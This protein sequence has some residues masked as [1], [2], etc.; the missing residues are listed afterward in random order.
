MSYC[1]LITFTDGE[2]KRAKEF[3]NSWGGA[4]RIWTPLYDRYLKDPN[5]PYDSWLF[6]KTDRLW[7]L[8]KRESLQLFERSVHAFTF[9]NAYVNKE[10]FGQMVVDL[11]AFACSYPVPQMVDHLP[12]WADFFDSCEADAVGLYGTSVS[13]NPW[14]DY[15]SDTDSET[16]V[17]L[18]KGFEVYDWLKG[19]KEVAA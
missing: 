19:K 1:Q 16:P 4:A 6:D 15:D 7:D 18:S 10:H 8:A 5:K 17:P 9:D 11:R 13:E 2:A 3:G 14:F 12:A